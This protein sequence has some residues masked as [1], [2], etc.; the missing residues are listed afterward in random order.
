MTDQVKEKLPRLFAEKFIAPIVADIK[1]KGKTPDQ[2]RQERKELMS[3]VDLGRQRL[4]ALKI[5][6]D[7][8]DEAEVAEKWLQTPEGK[9][10]AEMAKRAQAKAKPPKPAK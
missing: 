9:R 2:L 7:E 8:I 10:A 6:L 5:V 4:R 1:A 3:Q